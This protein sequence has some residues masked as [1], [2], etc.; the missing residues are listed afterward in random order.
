M[1][2]VVVSGRYGSFGWCGWEFLWC[3]VGFSG[4]VEISD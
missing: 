3:D 2:L 4:V 1:W